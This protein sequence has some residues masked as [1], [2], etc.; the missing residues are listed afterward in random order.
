MPRV[1]LRKRPLLRVQKQKVSGRLH[2]RTELRLGLL[3][4][5][6]VGRTGRK[7]VAPLLAHHGLLAVYMSE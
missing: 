6:L 2:D 3:L 1:T 4:E 7:R 5:W